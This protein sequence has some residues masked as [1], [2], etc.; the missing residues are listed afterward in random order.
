MEA[1]VALRVCARVG[2]A[3]ERRRRRWEGRGD[4][5]GSVDKVRLPRA[6]LAHLLALGPTNM[7]GWW[8]GGMVGPLE[9]G[10]TLMWT[11]ES[12]KHLILTNM[13]RKATN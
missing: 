6:L 2:A 8:R 3:G 5:G 1:A 13:D 11:S 4:C 7:I 12:S 10:H 9:N